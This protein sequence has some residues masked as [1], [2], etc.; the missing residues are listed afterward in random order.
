MAELP[1]GNSELVLSKSGEGRLHYLTAYRYRL[2]GNPPGR[3]QG[4]RVTRTVRPA[5]QAEVLFQQGLSPVEDA[6]TLDGGQ[7]YDIGLEI[8][9]DHP[10]N[11]VVITDPLPAGL[12]AVDTSFQTST[13]YFQPQQDSW[14]IGYQQLGRARILAYS[15]R[16]DPGVYSLHY[17][18]RS[19]T[20][21]TFLWPG[22][23]VQL[24]HAPEEFGRAAT[25]T[26]EIQE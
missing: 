5:N 2:P 6:I 17:L 21:G 10:V 7:V 8:I 16:L 9:T 25:A 4:L 19:V 22:S 26:L 23:Q 18:V 15:N 13:P 14:E 12:E 3:L 20:P 24:E 1:P 11:H